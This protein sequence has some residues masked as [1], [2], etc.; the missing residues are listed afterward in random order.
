MNGNVSLGQSVEERRA[1][2]MGMRK[3]LQQQA[4]LKN[5][6]QVGLINYGGTDGSS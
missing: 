5:V 2:Q 6:A 4:R 1:A 3:K